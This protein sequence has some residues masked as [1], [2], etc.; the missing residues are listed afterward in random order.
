V[1]SAKISEQT[2]DVLS[3]TF[4]YKLYNVGDRTEQCGI[5][6][7]ISLP[8]PI[9]QSSPDVAPAQTKQKALAV[10]YSLLLL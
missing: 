6:V 3:V 9:P 10:I 5:P 7:C 1:S 4:I 8:C 2:P